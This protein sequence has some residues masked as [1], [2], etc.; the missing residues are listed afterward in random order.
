MST[1]SQIQFSSDRSEALRAIESI[2]SGRG[3]CNVVPRVVDDV[4]DLRI[5]FTGL[6]ANQ[7]VVKASFV[8]SPPRHGEAQPSSL[9]VLHSRGRLG[10]ERIT[11]L[12]SGAPFTVLTGVDN[13]LTAIGTDRPNVVNPSAI[14]TGKQLTKTT[15]GNR[16]YIN[17]SA[18]SA[19]A[20]GTYGNE[21]RNSLRGPKYL[22]L[23]GELSRY[24]PIRENLKLDFRL[25][26]FNA[27]N[28]P[29]FSVPA[30]SSITSSTFGQISSTTYGA[31][32][33]QGAIKIIF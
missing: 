12:L 15:A 32:I 20:I 7:G 24:F 2:T 18:F 25:E 29:D 33:F 3:W 4:A 27:L 16:N 31:R 30:S 9:G 17:A 26:A 8:T 14:Y 5:N 23:D 13:S 10:R 19:N 1:R 21:G 22:Q 6:W 11:S 28:H